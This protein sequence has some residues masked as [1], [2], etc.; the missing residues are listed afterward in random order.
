MNDIKEKIK[1]SGFQ[2]HIINSLNGGMEYADLQTDLKSNGCN[3][4]QIDL[5]NYHK[6]ML[7]YG[8][9]KQ[10]KPTGEILASDRQIKPSKDILEVIESVK[11]EKPIDPK[12][13]VK[14][15][16]SLFTRQIAIVHKLQGEHLEDELVL[17][18][19]ELKNLETVQR[20]YVATL[21]FEKCLYKENDS[22]SEIDNQDK[23]DTNFSD[24]SNTNIQKENDT[25]FSDLLQETDTSFV[26]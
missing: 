18:N 3:F 23:Y 5:H 11:Q 12:L 2:V 25:D 7:N 15:L 24:L 9:S 6:S 8:N 19:N 26:S 14:M 1:Q 4:S 17:M 10:I 20:V 22:I 16:H 21:K 13:T